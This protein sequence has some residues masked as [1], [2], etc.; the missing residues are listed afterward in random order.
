MALHQYDWILAIGTI[1][2]FL[3]AWNIGA[4]DVANSWATSVSSRSVKYWQAMVLATIMEFAGGIGVGATVADTIRTK[5]IDVD[6]FES[7]PALLMLGMLCALVGSSTY[8]TFAT[9]IGLPVST[10][11]SIMG[12]VIGMGIALVG[13]DGVKWWGGNINSGVVQVFLAWVI[14]PFIS[15][16]FAAIIFLLTKY[17]ILLRSNPARKALY[18]IPFYFFVTC[19]LLAMLI[20]WKGGSSRIKLEGNEIAGTVVGTGAV[21]GALAAFFLVPWLYRRVILDDWAIRPWHL[22][23]GPLVLRRGEVPPRPEGVKTVQNYYRGHKTLEQIQAERAAGNDVET[24]NKS[25]PVTSTEGSPEI[26][27][28]ADPR[29]LASEPDSEPDAINITGPRPE[30]GNFHPAV[31]FWQAKRLFFR[32]IEKDVVSMQNKRN[33][34][35]GDLE[36]THAHADHFEN[37]AEYM[38]S[39]LQVLTA[40]T[41]S[42]AHGANDLSNAVGPYA[43]IYSI[44]RTAS[45]SG[46]GGS[47]K[48]DVPYW[49]LAFGGAS[50]VIGL[51]TYGY[52]IMRNLGNRITLHSPSRGFTMELGSAITVIMATKLKLP[53][54]T[55]QCITGATVGVGLCN[56]TYKTINWRMVAWIYMG[57]IIT[58]P[59]TGIISGCITG[60]I[61]NAPR[62]TVMIAK[63]GETRQLPVTL[64]SG[65][66][67][68]GKTT[69]LE[70]ILKSPSH[71]LRIAVIVND[72]SSLNIDAALITHHKVSQTK[73]KLIQ[74]QNGC[75]CCTLRG[76][77]LAELARLTK[78]KEVDYVVIESTGI[79]EP[80][81]VAETFTAE[82]SAAMLEVEGPQDSEGEGNSGATRIGGLHTLARLDTTVTVIDTF[83][84]LSNF[85]TAEFLSDRYGSDAIIPEDERTISD[86]MVDQIE[87]AD[88]LIMNKIE[89]VDEQTKNKIRRLIGMLNPDAKLIETSYSRVD[90]K[91][92]IGTGRFDFIKAASGAGWLRSLHEMSVLTTGVGKRV[93]P[94]PETL[95]YGINNF[96]YTARRPFHPRRL[97]SLIH[98][99]FILLQSLNTHDHGDDEEDEEDEENEEGEEDENSSNANTS[100]SG[101]EDSDTEI[102]D[103]SQPD[104]SLILANKRKSPFGPILRSKG[105]FWLATRPSHFGEWS[106][107]GSMLTVGCGGPWFAEVPDEA[108]PEDKDVRGSIERDFQG[109]WGD[110]R[111]ELVFIGEGLDVDDVTKLLNECLLDDKDMARWEKVMR[112]QKLSM[113][114]KVEKL[115]EM[116]EDGWEDWPEV[117]EMEM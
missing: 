50:L 19:T 18:T 15:A 7:N 92:I 106:Q 73:E 52:N 39:F 53:V 67:G 40:S 85:N 14:A 23:L 91:E 114:E 1:F 109:E 61:I 72:M 112:S 13:A 6:L 96:V 47:G 116:W 55:T 58:L 66:L 99:K 107:A 17:L 35:T 59:V 68:S 88:V 81:Q 97:F 78:Q 48:T 65:F 56:G 22:L 29:V 28:K 60:I 95:E 34:L 42:F 111:Q 115:A 76:D 108:W 62:K 86:L 10:T 80:M 38:F 3:D 98:D 9:R 4:N 83:N 64:L 90:V 26:E 102:T 93:A 24:A 43:T 11:H 100:E 45:L 46:S 2:A 101:E 25:T 70:H 75:I 94:R 54:S 31:L 82:F 117:E 71:G 36:M 110:R 103:F 113:S 51:W 37:R 41:A 44:W 87:F 57:W 30:G 32:G 105:F 74:L 21:M 69:L 77:L 8:L 79:S 104:Q 84:L 20:V 63:D 89:T 33:V 5:V 49:I 12:G 27:P 16:A